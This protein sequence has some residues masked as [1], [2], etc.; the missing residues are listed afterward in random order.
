M[1][2]DVEGGILCATD[3]ASGIGAAGLSIDVNDYPFLRLIGW[4]SVV[5]FLKAFFFRKKI[6]VWID[7]SGD[8][9]VFATIIFYTFHF[10]TRVLL[11]L[12]DLVTST[13][14]GG[15]NVQETGGDHGEVEVADTLLEMLVT[16]L[17]NAL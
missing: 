1:F 2:K 3:F 6:A 13:K 7:K 11:I 15:V 12:L 17:K 9:V 8:S 10:S 5:H 14:D 16:S 4:Q